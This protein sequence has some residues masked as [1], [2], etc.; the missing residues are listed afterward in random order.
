MIPS[1]LIDRAEATLLRMS[2]TELERLLRQ[3]EPKLSDAQLEVF[4]QVGIDGYKR[5]H[6][7]V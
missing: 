3:W 5:R 7:Q 1:F 6:R 2:P 4:V